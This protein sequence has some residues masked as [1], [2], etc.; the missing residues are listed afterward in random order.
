MGEDAFA[1]CKTL[2][3]VTIGS[4]I[5]ALSKGAFYDSPVKEVYVK[6]AVPPAMSSYVFLSKPVIHVSA[7]AVE[8]YKASAWAEFGTIVGDLDDSSSAK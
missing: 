3:K 6:A 7:A 5:K 1:Y 4:G 2:K 8:A